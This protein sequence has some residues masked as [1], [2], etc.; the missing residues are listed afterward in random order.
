PV[1]PGEPI[2]QIAPDE[3]NRAEGMQSNPAAMKPEL[4]GDDSDRIDDEGALGRAFEEPLE[5]APRV[6]FLRHHEA[7]LSAGR[8]RWPLTSAPASG[9]SLRKLQS[10]ARPTNATAAKASRKSAKVRASLSAPRRRSDACNA[11]LP[12]A[13]PIP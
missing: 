2:L 10:A 12:K 11:T 5:A 6:R 8:R 13:T 3:E 7:S 1:H 9:A 4:K